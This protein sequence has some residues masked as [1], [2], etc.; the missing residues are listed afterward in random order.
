MSTVDSKNP[1]AH[2]LNIIMKNI[3]LFMMNETYFEESDAQK[4]LSDAIVN[5]EKAAGIL[6]ANDKLEEEKAK[7]GKSHE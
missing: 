2:K 1:R 4:E 6:I 5:I 7:E 3:A